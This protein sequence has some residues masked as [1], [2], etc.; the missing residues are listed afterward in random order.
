MRENPSPSNP[1]ARNWR[2]A[3]RLHALDLNVIEDQQRPTHWI[4]SEPALAAMAGTVARDCTDALRLGAA[5][6]LPRSPEEF[7]GRLAFD[8]TRR[9]RGLV[10]QTVFTWRFARACARQSAAARAAE[11]EALGMARR[12]TER[13]S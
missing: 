13:H 2:L 12:R 6:D 1:L 10:A 7:V 5:C 3:F 9:P 8:F 4:F 11:R